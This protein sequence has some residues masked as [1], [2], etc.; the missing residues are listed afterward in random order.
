MT[1]GEPIAQTGTYWQQFISLFVVVLCATCG[2]MLVQVLMKGVDIKSGSVGPIKIKP[3]LTCITIPPLVGMII[4]GCLARNFLGQEYMQHY[5]NI[6]AS[7][8]RMICLSII[9]LRGGLE[10]DFKGKGMTVVLLTLVP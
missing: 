1:A 3:V 8:V 2:G 9:L 4:F 10:L 6:T 5:P 7:W